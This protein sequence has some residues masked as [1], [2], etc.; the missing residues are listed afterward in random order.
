MGG[1]L[2]LVKVDNAP[3]ARPQIGLADAGLI[4]EVPVEGGMTRFTALYLG[5]APP[6]VGPVRS[7]RPVDAD[8]LAPFPGTVIAT[9]G[10]P[11]VVGMVTSAG[12]ALADPNTSGLLQA[13]ERPRPHNLFATLANAPLALPL[14]TRAPWSYGPWPGGETASSVSLATGA[15]LVEWRWEGDVW[16]RYS[17]GAPTEVMAALEEP[18]EPLARQV[19]ILLAANRKSGGYFDSAG[20]EVPDFDVVGGGEL[21]ILYD[22]QVAEGTWSRASQAQPW[23]FFDLDGDPLAVPVGSLFMAVVPAESAVTINS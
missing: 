1:N 14:G 20:A 7:L 4:M 8:L 10:Q 6:L 17:D 18:S 3:G 2:V 13:L 15:E 9:G 23:S 11:H 16:H 22:G 19:V 21:W 12:I 5:D